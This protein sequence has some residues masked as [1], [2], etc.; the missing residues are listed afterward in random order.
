MTLRELLRALSVPRW[1]HGM[2]VQPRNEPQFLSPIEVQVN[3]EFEDTQP[4]CWLLSPDESRGHM[5]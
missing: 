3:D 4:E 1:R 2:D 5:H